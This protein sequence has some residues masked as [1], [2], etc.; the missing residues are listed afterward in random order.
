MFSIQIN[1]L[2]PAIIT[3]LKLI[4]SSQ[5]KLTSYLYGKRLD[6]TSMQRNKRSFGSHKPWWRIWKNTDTDGCK[7]RQTNENGALTKGI[8]SNSTEDQNDQEW[9]RGTLYGVIS[10]SSKAAKNNGECGDASF[11]GKHVNTNR[12]STSG[13]RFQWPV[14]MWLKVTSCYRLQWT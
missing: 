14:S 6:H 12:G 9:G 4:C 13:R 2:C 8:H 5:I 3:L 10:E 7:K 11:I 1:H